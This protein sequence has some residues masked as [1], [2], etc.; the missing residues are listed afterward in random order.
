MSSHG[1]LTDEQV[2]LFGSSQGESVI[3]DRQK[4]GRQ[5]EQVLIGIGRPPINERLRTAA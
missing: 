2:R 3:R 4:V 5:L 1:N